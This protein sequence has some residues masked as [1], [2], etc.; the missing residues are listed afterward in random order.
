METNVEINRIEVADILNNYSGEFFKKHKLSFQQLKAINAIKSCRTSWLGYHK[1]VCNAYPYQ[2]ISYNSCRNRHCP[3]CQLTKQMKWI[4]KLKA[5]VL[6][7][8]HFHIVFTLP[9]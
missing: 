4:D 2:Q 7:V 3:K 1:L 5:S 6:P 9:C 8:R